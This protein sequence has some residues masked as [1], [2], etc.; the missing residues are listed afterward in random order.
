[1]R[2]M[3]IDHVIF[4]CT[5][6]LLGFVV[7]VVLWNV[8]AQMGHYETA[9]TQELNSQAPSKVFLISANRALDFVLIRS[10]ALIFGVTLTLLGALYLFKVFDTPFDLSAG[11]AEKLN[12]SFKT[13]S[14]GLV[15]ITLGVVLVI[16]T[17]YAR[18]TVSYNYEA[19]PG[20]VRETAS[21]APGDQT[22]AAPATSDSKV[23][24]E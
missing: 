9:L 14:P 24:G 4:A 17:V 7:G 2:R 10:A 16:S 15:M 21:S 1:M 13:S 22:R 11:G 3:K 6:L 20:R 5:L 19:V 23:G 18:S 12:L 8:A